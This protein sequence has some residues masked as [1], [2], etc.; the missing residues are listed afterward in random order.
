M[1]EPHEKARVR[2]RRGLAVT[3]PGDRCASA[4]AHSLTGTV[5]FFFLIKLSLRI[6]LESDCYATSSWSLFWFS[7]CLLCKA[8]DAVGGGSSHTQVLHWSIAVLFLQWGCWEPRGL[9]R[10]GPG[11][12]GLEGHPATTL[13]GD[14]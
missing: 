11:S 10:E 3:L 7:I 9:G 5:V 14:G 8:T 2:S 4:L 6:E 1:L 13:P 12:G